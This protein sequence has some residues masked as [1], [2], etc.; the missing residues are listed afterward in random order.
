MSSPGEQTDGLSR[1]VVVAN[2]PMSSSDLLVFMPTLS[3]LMNSASARPN[4]LPN[5]Y[6]IS[7][8]PVG[9]DVEILGSFGL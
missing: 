3:G 6:S 4:T 2:K 5:T 1:D 9:L 7:V 8:C